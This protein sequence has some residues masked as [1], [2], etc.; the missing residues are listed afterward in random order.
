MQ[1]KLALADGT[2]LRGRA[3]GARGERGGEVVF[4]TA[5][6]GYQEILTDPSYRGQIVVMTA[7]HVGN[8]GVNADDVESRRPWGE[9]FV[10]RS[11]THRPSNARATGDLESYLRGAGI[12]GM[13]DLDTRAL[14]RRLRVEGAM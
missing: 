10:A 9:G 1:A 6:T 2:V 12:V 11:V 4:N 3:F 5:M 13:E 8:T 7:A 14:T